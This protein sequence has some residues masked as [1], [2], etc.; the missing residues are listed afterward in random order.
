MGPWCG[1]LAVFLAVLALLGWRMSEG[2][3]PALG[4]SAPAAASTARPVLVKHIKRT[5]I[6]TR[7]IGPAGAP[8]PAA[9]NRGATSSAAP[10]PVASAPAPAPAAAPAPA[11]V[12]RTS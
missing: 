11:P 12:T 9:A 3:D 6:V 10:A 7:V 2:R 8:A 1:G 5:V 4:A